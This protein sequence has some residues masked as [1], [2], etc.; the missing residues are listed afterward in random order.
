M[1]VILSIAT[2]RRVMNTP[3]P[4][5]AYAILK[6]LAGQA[7]TGDVSWE[8]AVNSLS[9]VGITGLEPMREARQIVQEAGDEGAAIALDTVRT[10]LTEIRAAAILTR[11]VRELPTA[12]ATERDGASFYFAPDSMVWTAAERTRGNAQ[13]LSAVREL[14]SSV[15]INK[16]DPAAARVYSDTDMWT[17]AEAAL[18]TNAGNAR[19]KLLSLGL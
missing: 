1:A 12:L 18:A 17:R 19:Q 5:N 3:K 10:L 8:G 14:L 2:G 16:I 7:Q 6:E 11:A 9:H 15:G 13:A 4:T